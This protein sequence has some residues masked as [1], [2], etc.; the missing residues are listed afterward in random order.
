[1]TCYLF[2][3]RQFL[4]IRSSLACFSMN[5]I[6]GNKKP[7]SKYSLRYFFI[8]AAIYANREMVKSFKSRTTTSQTIENYSLVNIGSNF[9]FDEIIKIN[10]L[11]CI[12][13]PHP[14]ICNFSYPL[15]RGRLSVYD[16]KGTLDKTF[17]KVGLRNEVLFKYS[18]KFFNH[19]PCIKKIVIVY[20]VLKVYK[21]FLQL[22]VISY[23]IHW[24]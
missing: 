14:R 8:L 9:K 11:A 17:F 2:I 21:I 3:F 23:P 1:M 12:C 19:F 6:F 15:L 13:H 20:I 5:S 10:S 24:L 16:T 7:R 4:V 18:Q 22:I